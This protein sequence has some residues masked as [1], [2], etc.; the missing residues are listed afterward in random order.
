MK[1]TDLEPK[2]AKLYLKHPVSNKI[3]KDDSKQEVY[4][5]VVGR[6]S[7]EYHNSQ[8]EFINTLQG[9]GEDA[10]DNY[11]A[12]DLQKRAVN[13]LTAHVV[14]WDKKFN[15]FFETFDDSDGSY[16]PELVH[17]ILSNRKYNWLLKQIDD[18]V[19]ERE[20]FFMNS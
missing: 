7:D 20:H 1:L 3:I 10:L 14:G 18:Y 13:Q 8:Q 16:T 19:A 12:D 15:S 2:T 17:S 4:L 11:T 6:D 5:N 9:L